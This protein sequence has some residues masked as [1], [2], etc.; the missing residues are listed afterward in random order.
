MKMRIFGCLFLAVFSANALAQGGTKSPYSQYGIGVLTDPS[1]GMNRGMNGVGM[2]L[3]QGN[4]VNTLNPA[5]YSSIDSLTMIFDAG[6]VGQTTNFK[7]GGLRQN[8]SLGNFEYAVG[9]FR[10]VN[11]VGMAFGVLPLSNVGYEYTSTSSLGTGNGS[12]T[13]TYSGSGGLHQ[14][15]IGAGA[16]VFGPLSVG[17]NVAFLWGS[18]DRSVATAASSAVNGLTKSYSAN[19]KNYKVD[20]GLQWR[21]PVG[22]TDYVTLGATFGLGH[23][24]HADPEMLIISRNSYS[25]KSDTTKFVVSNGLSLPHSFGVGLA[26]QKGQRLVV[27]ADATLQKWGSESFPRFNESA[28][29]YEPSSN[30]L[31]D[32]LSMNVGAQWVPNNQGRKFLQ[33]VSY[34]IGAGYASPYYKI[35]G[36]NGPDELSVSAGLGIPIMNGYNSRSVFNVSA[37]W[38]RSSASGFITENTF[39][40]NLGLT[41]NERWFAKW[42]VE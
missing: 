37:Q 3:W 2:A 4:Q 21:Q 26:Y 27:A 8:A 32:R 9:S 12:V 15:F 28:N 41:F 24:L 33:H 36:Q 6:L 35:N 30:V 31:K 17:A 38:V 22:K 39:R 10:L 5:S 1:Q 34:R 11:K 29:R 18:I 40:I 19:V 25:G 13:Q 23:K 20:F 7:E 14:A 16:N 42:R